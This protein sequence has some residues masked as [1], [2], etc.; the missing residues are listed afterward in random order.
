MREA[1]LISAVLRLYHTRD[2]TLINAF[3]DNVL[4]MVELTPIRDALVSGGLRL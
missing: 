3:V 1:L 2:Q 4:D